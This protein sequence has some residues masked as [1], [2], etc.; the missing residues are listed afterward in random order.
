MI[1]DLQHNFHD[2]NLRRVSLG[3][4][5][6][7]TLICELDLCFNSNAAPVVAVRFGGI[8][9]YDEVSAFLT[10]AESTAGHDSVARVD[11]LDYDEMESSTSRNLRF[12]LDLD[13]TGTLKIH[14]QNVTVTDIEDESLN[15]YG[16][17]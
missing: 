12:R 9:N 13:G 7:V 2:A 5:R 10:P 8:E 6:E 1:P 17:T 11:R 16:A 15:K 3:P 4:R 14:C